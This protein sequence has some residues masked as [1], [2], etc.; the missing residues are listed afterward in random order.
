MRFNKSLMT[1][2]LLLS[3][4]TLNAEATLTVFNAAG[5]TPVVYS[6]LGDITWTADANLLGTLEASN[7]GLVNTIISTIGTVHDTPSFYDNGTYTLT[8]NDFGS[9]GKVS[10]WGAK[11]F[12]QYLN[13]VNYGGSN[14]WALPTA[15]PQI[16][17]SQF[18]KL[19][20]GELHGTEGSNIPN[21]TAF[22]NEQA[23]SYWSGEEYRFNINTAFFF[24]TTEGFELNDFKHRQYFAW[25]VS[26]GQMAVVPV[27]GAVWMFGTGLLGLV[28]L[29]RRGHGGA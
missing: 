17:G 26:P 15:S 21:T 8:A 14:Q 25:A 7:S 9:D 6:S 28:S 2:G 3:L 24:N 22:S 5:N 16:G 20:Y 11:A 1:A 4:T 13:S 27:P 19:F 18:S 29:T 10:W 23:S 12:T